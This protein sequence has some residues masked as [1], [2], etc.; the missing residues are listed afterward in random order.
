MICL[1]LQSIQFIL[2]P[3]KLMREGQTI[4]NL[5]IVSKD[6][7]GL[8]TDKLLTKEGLSLNLYIQENH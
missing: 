5:F 3:R 7:I 2:Q 1:R 6:L 8:K 4:S